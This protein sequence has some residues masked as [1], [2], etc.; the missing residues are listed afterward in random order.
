VR[1]C[2]ASKYGISDSKKPLIKG[3]EE[4]SSSGAPVYLPVGVILFSALYLR[5]ISSLKI[6]LIALNVPAGDGTF[7][8][9]IS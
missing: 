9:L 3:L 6:I 7:T 4:S 2:G 8:D 1:C 5:R